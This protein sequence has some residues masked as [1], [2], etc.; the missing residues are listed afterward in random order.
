MNRLLATLLI[1]LVGTALHAALPEAVRQACFSATA[2]EHTT[3][4][5][6]TITSWEAWSSGGV[7]IVET[8]GE[9]RAEQAGLPHPSDLAQTHLA[10]ITPEATEANPN[11]I[12]RLTVT[13]TPSGALNPF[14]VTL[15]LIANRPLPPCQVKP[16]GKRLAIVS[17]TNDWYIIPDDARAKVALGKDDARHTT[18]S[19]GPMVTTERHPLTAT[20]LV[21]EGPLPPAPAQ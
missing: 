3:G 5:A 13:L 12:Q 15:T 8:P 9:T 16:W 21:G 20:L 6:W 10:V 2:Q 14:K 11:P 4:A 18:V 17:T 7:Q 1:A 19:I